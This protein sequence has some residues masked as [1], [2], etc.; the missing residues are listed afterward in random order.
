MWV[1]SPVAA[2]GLEREVAEIGAALAR[3]G[4]PT[5]RRELAVLVGARFWGPGRFPAALRAAVAAGVARRV[6][7]GRFEAASGRTAAG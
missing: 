1:S 2:V 3:R 5:D 6:A 7:R 4:E